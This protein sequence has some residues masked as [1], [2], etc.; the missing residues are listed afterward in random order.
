[1]KRLKSFGEISRL[2][3]LDNLL[4]SEGELWKKK[5]RLVSNIFNYDFIKRK[6]P[7]IQQIFRRSQ[8]EAEQKFQIDEGVFRYDISPVLSNCFS[9]VILECFFRT[10]SDHKIDGVSMTEYSNKLISDLMSSA[11]SPFRFFIGPGFG[12]MGFL[13]RERDINERIK[14]FRKFSSEII[15]NRMEEIQKS[16]DFQGKPRD[17]VEALLL[18]GNF[19]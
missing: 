13:K 8:V 4:L 7:E 18:S 2:I 16:N 1:M 9:E 11:R 15:R 14:K 5:R 19:K 17:I 3:N 10:T 12:R 6:I